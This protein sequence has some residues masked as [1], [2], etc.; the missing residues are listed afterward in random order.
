MKVL[1]TGALS[2]LGLEIARVFYEHGFEVYGTSRKERAFEYGKILPLDFSCPDYSVLDEIEECDVLV[3][4]AGIFTEGKTGSLSA[5]DFDSVIDVNIRG[6]YHVT[7]RML[8][9]LKKS[10]GSIVN[11]SSMNAM[12]PGFGLTS[13]Y[14]GSKGFVSSFTKSLASETGLRVNAVC[15]GLIRAPRLEGTELEK[16]FS[17][18]SVRK[19]MMEAEDIAELVYFLAVSQG[20]YGQSIIIDNGYSLL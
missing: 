11:I 5:E 10:N 18:H 12:H 2:N 14:D 1:I 17:S 3:N 13:H 19:K 9:L 16:V 15:P 8:P 4:N 20:I 6:L 7:E